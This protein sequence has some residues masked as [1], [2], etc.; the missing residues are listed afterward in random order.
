MR[1]ITEKA[2][3][4]FEN[5]KNFKLQNT[6]IKVSSDGNVSMYLW[7]HEIARK[8]NGKVEI[9]MQGYNTVTTR[10]RLNGLSNVYLYQR[11]FAPVLNGQE[12][13]PCEWYEIGV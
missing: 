2:C 8:I 1:K 6:E 12:I 11:N 5:G 3:R 13:S 10:E 4:A 7:G 9:N